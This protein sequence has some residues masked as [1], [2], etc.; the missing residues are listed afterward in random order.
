MNTLVEIDGGTF[1]DINA[2]ATTTITTTATSTVV[3]I[4]PITTAF[5]ITTIAAIATVAA[6]DIII[7]HAAHLLVTA[8]SLEGGGRKAIRR[9]VKMHAP[10]RAC[11]R[12]ERG[13]QATGWVRGEER[14]RGERHLQCRRRR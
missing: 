8:I 3:F 11:L 7:R 12:V 2:R 9:H 1:K 10:M 6:A 4:S 5:Y 13:I 14:R